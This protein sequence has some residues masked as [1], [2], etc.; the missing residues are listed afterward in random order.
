MLQ[1]IALAVSRLNQLGRL[2]KVYETR[3]TLGSE[4]QKG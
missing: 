2:D 3:E 4:L 1:Q